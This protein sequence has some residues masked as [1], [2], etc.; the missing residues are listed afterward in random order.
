[1]GTDLFDAF[2]LV[3]RRESELFEG[4]DANEVVAAHLWRY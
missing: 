3:R 4:R 2:L 1:M